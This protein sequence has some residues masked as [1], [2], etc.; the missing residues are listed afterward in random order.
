MKADELLHVLPTL[1]SLVQKK[2]ACVFNVDTEGTL[3]E[4]VSSDPSG[5]GFPALATIS[6]T[7][8]GIVT[9]PSV[10]QV[11]DFYILS[12]VATKKF[13]L[14]FVHFYN[15]SL[16]V[17]NL[18][19]CCSLIKTTTE[20]QIPV[21]LTEYISQ[22]ESTKPSVDALDLIIRDLKL[23]CEMVSYSG[24][25]GATAAVVTI[26]SAEELA[27]HIQSSNRTGLLSVNLYRPWPKDSLFRALPA[28][29]NG[30]EIGEC[31][32][33]LVKTLVA[34]ENTS[35]T[36]WAPLFLDIAASVQDSEVFAQFFHSVK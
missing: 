4:Y 13:Q 29:G 19:P 11:S 30:M 17:M 26:G 28:T 14:P 9:S 36:K 20:T 22:Q 15:G 5:R 33:F 16:Q 32:L 35:V 23:K 21:G 2:V 25:S 7:G 27:R 31:L 3:G 24:K 6:Q 8:V 34:L 1:D 10:E 18:V 12:R